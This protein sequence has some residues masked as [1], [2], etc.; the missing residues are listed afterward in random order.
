MDSVDISNYSFS[1][2]G[3]MKITFF[4]NVRDTVADIKRRQLNESIQA[5]L[6]AGVR[7]VQRITP[8][9]GE[10]YS[11]LNSDT[12]FDRN[13]K[14]S[15]DEMLQ[16]LTVKEYLKP[17]LIGFRIPF[18]KDARKG[19]LIQLLKMAIQGNEQKI[20]QLKELYSRYVSQ[21]RRNR[22]RGQ[23]N[24]NSTLLI[25]NHYKYKRSDFDGMSFKQIL[26]SLFNQDEHLVFLYKNVLKERQIPNGRLN[27]IVKA[28]KAT[29]GMTDEQKI[30]YYKAESLKTNTIL[31]ANSHLVLEILFS[32]KNPFYINNRNYSILSFQQEARPGATPG[33]TPEFLMSTQGI[34]TTYVI[35]PVDIYLVLSDK[36]SDKITTK[37]IQAA[38]CHLSAEN[39]R[40]NWH[41][42]WWQDIQY[43]RKHY[44]ELS[45]NTLPGSRNIIGGAS[46]K[47]KKHR[48]T[49][50]RKH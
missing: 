48:K 20:Q 27:A 17:M 35:Y 29:E 26:Q 19:E 36:P 2:D 13:E 10:S 32:S 16:A 6:N 12:N 22:Q 23:R 43:E 21:L 49:K 46:Y 3:L 8:D 47:M 25:S 28:K 30:S 40:K 45:R 31:K 34:A 1:R 39:I 5:S 14:L 4:S 41:D 11:V 7:S 37:D 24:V 15:I 18:N 9:I 33:A 44:N 38:S 50:K 42:I